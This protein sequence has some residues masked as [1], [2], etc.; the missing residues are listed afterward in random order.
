MIIQKYKTCVFCGS[1]KL[2]VNKCQKFIHNFYTRSIKNDL[3]LNDIFFKKM[4]TYK[5]I[6]CHVIQNNPW[7]SKK[8]SFKIFNQIYGQHNRN[9]LN[10]LN[11]FQKGLKPNHGNLFNILVKNFKIKKY[12]EFNAPFMG[13]MIDFFD[14]EY[15]QNSKFNRNIFNYSLSYLSSRQLAGFN[16]SLRNKKEK[17]A[18]KNLKKLNKFKNKISVNNV[19]KKTLIVDN[20]YLSWLYNDNYKSVNSRS[21]ASELFDIDIEEFNLKKKSKKYDLFGLFNTLDHTHQ[22]KKILDYALNNSKYVLIYY[23]SNENLERQHLFSLTNKFIFYLKKN[24]IFCSNLTLDISKK[25]KTKEVYILCSK[26][27][28][29]NI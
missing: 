4:K 26:F 6:N 7:F 5:C 12:C 17:E 15:N 16:K 24:K 8:T 28:K 27:N 29:V 13:L 20:S 19:I 1:G 14:K 22:P 10:V 2:K 11:F 23:H 21:L 18:K 25:F 9:W 3:D